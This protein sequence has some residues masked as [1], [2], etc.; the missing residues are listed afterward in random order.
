MTIVA[1]PAAPFQ[2]D[3]ELLGSAVSLTVEPNE[4]GLTVLR[5]E[6]DQSS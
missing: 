5:P 1:E 6:P 4:T 3:G 2:A